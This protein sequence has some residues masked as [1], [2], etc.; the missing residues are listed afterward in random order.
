MRYTS[1]LSILLAL[2]IFIGGCYISW[3]SDKSIKSHN[4][5]L[6]ISRIKNQVKT[7]KKELLLI[8]RVSEMLA[9]DPAVKQLFNASS[10]TEIKD[11][12]K[13]LR[14]YFE[15]IRS[16]GNMLTIYLL[17]EDGKCVVATDLSF[18]GN[19]YGFRPYFKEAITSEKGSYLAKGVTSL[20][21]GLY[22]SES[23]NG[24]NRNKGVI[25][26]KID[27]LLLF[28]DHDIPEENT[29][30]TSA[31]IPPYS[32]W[33]ATSKGI[34][35]SPVQKGFY[36]LSAMNNEQ[37]KTIKKLR[38]FE[39]V[40]I[41]ELGFSPNTWNQLL[42]SKKSESLISSKKDEISYQLNRF[43]LIPGRLYFVAAFSSKYKNP[44]LTMLDNSL[45]TLN[46]AFL[47]ALIPL[48]FMAVYLK[49]QH[50]RLQMEK[51]IKEEGIHRYEAVIENMRNGFIAMERKTLKIFDFNNRFLELLEMTHNEIQNISFIDLVEDDEKENFLSWLND[52]SGTQ[53]DFTTILKNSSG[54]T[55]PIIFDFH[56]L[57]ENTV[58]VPFF[59][60][61]V[62]D[63]RKKIQNAD[64]LRILET[65][66]EQ[67]ANNIVIT[68]RHGTIEYV[69]PSFTKLTGYSREEA[70]GQ[71]PRVLKSGVHDDQH[72]KELWKTIASGN[73]WRGRL[74]NRRKNGSLYWEN[75]VIAPIRNHKGKIEHYIAVKDD[76]TERI[77]LEEELHH[78]MAELELIMQH[79]TVGIAHIKNMCFVKVNPA[80][81]LIAGMAEDE[82]NGK[83]TKILFGSEREWIEFGEK[84]YPTLMKGL[85]INFD[86]EFLR[87]DGKKIWLHVNASTVKPDKLEN[88]DTVWVFQDITEARKLAEKLHMAKDEAEKASRAKGDFLANMSHE[89]RTPLNA[90]IGMGRLLADTD[91]DEKQQKYMRTVIESSNLLL[92]IINDILDFSKIEAGELILERHYFNIEDILG[93]I[94]STMSGLAHDKMLLLN[95]RRDPD[96]PLTYIGDKVRL[97][98]IIVN[99]LNNAIKFTGKG[100]VSL[101]ASVD[102]IADNNAILKF[103]VSDTG[104]G[105]A[106]EDMNKLFKEF[107]Q[108]D[109]SIGRRFG[110]TGLGLAICKRIVKLMGGEIWVK[111]ELG[112]GSTFT[113]TVCCEI[114]KGEIESKTITIHKKPQESLTEEPL[115]ILLVEDNMANRELATI[116]LE[117]AGHSV[118]SAENG[119]DALSLLSKKQFDVI[120]M[121]VQMPLLDGLTTTE[122]IRSFENGI[123][124]NDNRISTIMKKSLKG[125]LYGKK[126]PIIAMTA[127]AMS[128][129][130]QRC[131]DAGMDDYITKPFNIEEIIRVLSNVNPVAELPDKLVSK[132][133]DVPEHNVFEQQDLKDNEGYYE[134]KP[135]DE[136]SL[137]N[138]LKK[139][140]NITDEQTLFLL[141]AF[142]TTT[143]ETL[144]NLKPHIAK[145]DL[146]G[147]AK[148]AHKLKGGL[149]Q[150]GL[151]VLGDQAKL[152]EENAQKGNDIDFA[153]EVEKLEKGINKIIN[154][155]D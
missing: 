26:L 148:T 2:L 14:S 67:S 27:P 66:V 90:I 95:I 121:D 63:L 98:Q 108:T 136:D 34:M 112:K 59:Y 7:I 4:R 39:G 31:D 153:S 53:D 55:V 88:M 111:S 124:P 140:F 71:N 35:F 77:R 42:S 28:T 85:T 125:S 24:K 91:L 106:A 145:K 105:I 33:L 13:I 107:Q 127:N 61:F 10:E 147:I 89:I 79:T 135:H 141:K 72:Y 139:N 137:K 115:Y 152:I 52:I 82:L 110:G 19:N 113:F 87:K 100:E 103:E 68:N 101:S 51:R 99:L 131:I 43:T 123:I 48:C 80:M 40:V 12:K 119:L 150:I 36:T 45:I 149:M 22:L 6:T 120:F 132:S 104:I 130:K 64:K 142:K 32:I 122:L 134:A 114:F 57:E 117:K 11:L 30:K 50:E 143:R 47:V 116:V 86:Y 8:R 41:K 81:A 25:V 138:W 65:A 60:A 1:Q 15:E 78:K 144:K 76:I 54:A 70:I 97:T 75:A 83:Q 154:I 23:V 46:I 20:R 21:L 133:E 62:V 56:K 17:D 18:E 29:P 93:N 73:V 92:G 109:S 96:M 69:N 9:I 146:K 16:A 44:A 5:E 102:S 94:K 151:D 155:Y 129:D 128:G 84:S 58:S 74:C 49:K 38:Q 37:E 118:H 126:V 3:S